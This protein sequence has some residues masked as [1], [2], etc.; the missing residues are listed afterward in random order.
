MQQ[1]SLSEKIQSLTPE[2]V[3]E[4]EEFIATLSAH[5]PHHSLRQASTTLS[6]A[7]FAAVWDNPEDD[8]YDA[9]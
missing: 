7:A 6:E 9:L 1:I 8:V 2:Q 5:D 3:L 4:V